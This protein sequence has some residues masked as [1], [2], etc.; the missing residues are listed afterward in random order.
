MSTDIIGQ[1]NQLHDTL[2]YLLLNLVITAPFFYLDIYFL[3]NT[4]FV[5]APVYIP[6]VA[7]YSIS[8]I[9][10]FSCILIIAIYNVSRGKTNTE[11]MLLYNV[12]LSSLSTFAMSTTCLYF[13][14]TLRAFFNLSA[15]AFFAFFILG[16]IF[17]LLKNLCGS[18]NNT[19]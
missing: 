2:K 15:K 5:N 12:I 10:F 4:M 6:I 13:N 19:N 18:N 9:W 1:I 16:F 17:S 11:N 8:M 7:A 3:S 14:Y